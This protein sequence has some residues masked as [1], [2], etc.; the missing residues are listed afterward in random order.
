MRASRDAMR[1]P[2]RR[3]SANDKR[4]SVE[5]VGRQSSESE[6][7]FVVP[8][9]V[10]TNSSGY[11][12]CFGTSSGVVNG[13]IQVNS[14]GRTAYGTYSGTYTG[15]NSTNCSGSSTSTTIATPPRDVSYTVNG[16]TLSLQLPDGRVAVVNCDSKFNWTDWSS[17]TPR[18]S[19]R[20]PTSNQFDAE[21]NGDK[22]KLIWQIGIRGEKTQSETYKLIEILEPSGMR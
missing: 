8:G 17:W 18:R 22:A 15:T 11:A 14:Y 9:Y 4:I 2:V 13:S 12:N 1:V 7:S 5:V 10:S 19:C 20:I 16:A 21:F 6:Y 3:E